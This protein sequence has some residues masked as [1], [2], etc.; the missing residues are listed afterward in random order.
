MLKSPVPFWDKSFYDHHGRWSH[1]F[2]QIAA[3]RKAIRKFIKL[4]GMGGDFSVL[5]I[6]PSIGT[7]TAYLRENNIHV[8]T[9]DLKP[10]YCPDIIGSILNIPL[11]DSS[12]DMV[13]TCEVFEHL[14]YQ[15]FLNALRE[16]Y[17]VTKKWAFISIPDHRSI[18]CKLSLKIPILKEKHFMIRIQSPFERRSKGKRDGH[19]WEIGHK[20]FPLSRII[21][22]IARAGFTITSVI[23]PYDNTKSVY[24]FLTK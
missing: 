11:P 4:G 1:Y 13:L 8:T 7:L 6:G 5:E 23:H 16:V 17:R 14:P 9:C 18:I 21:S 24:F 3:V 15:D 19:Y 12:F 22:D 2:Y 20:G 10:E